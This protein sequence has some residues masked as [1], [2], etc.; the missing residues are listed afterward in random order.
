MRRHRAGRPIGS[1]PLLSGSCAGRGLLIG[2]TVQGAGPL[3]GSKLGLRVA[4]GRGRG[5]AVQLDA[6]RG[7]RVA[8]EDDLDREVVPVVR[9]E[10]S[11]QGDVLS[12]W[13]PE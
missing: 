3:R 5:L 12:Q 13:A 1:P 10:R 8:E 11:Q 6:A 4:G 9:K 2:R 7:R